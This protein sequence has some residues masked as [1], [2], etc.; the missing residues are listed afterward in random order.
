MGSPKSR[1]VSAACFLAI[2]LFLI[3]SSR[4]MLYAAGA[5][6][7][8]RTINMVVPLPPGGVT[9]LSAR[10]L[11]ETM[12][13]LLKQPIAVLNKPGGASTI[14]GYAVA[15]AKPDGYTLGFFPFSAT[16]PEVF[17]YFFVAPYTSSDFKPISRFQSP[18]LTVAVRGDAPWNSLKEFIEY[19]RKNPGTKFAH[20]GKSTQQFVVPTM[21]ARQEKL[22]MV[23]VPY[24]GDATMV[25]ALLGGHVPI[26]TP[27]YPIIKALVDAKKLKLLAVVL[28]KRLAAAPEV[29]SLYELGYRSPLYAYGGLF[30]PK[31]TPDDI[32]RKLDEAVRQAS[33]DRELQNRAKN[34]DLLLTYEDTATFERSIRQY[35]EALHAFFVEEGMIKAK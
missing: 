18:I 28:D 7:P 23:D 25:P 5:D 27:V 8:N 26:G 1:I 6:Y 31:G 35:K 9:D 34:M 12:E 16:A 24:D 11:A 21:I 32:I 20:L 4:T 2:G 3:G 15:S 19:A 22:R 33:E 14:G 30:A 13:K 17:S 10:L 29:P